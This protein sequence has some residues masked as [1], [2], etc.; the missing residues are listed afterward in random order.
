MTGAIINPSAA[1]IAARCWRFGIKAPASIPQAGWTSSIFMSV[2]LQNDW[3]EPEGDGE[4]RFTTR[5]VSD[6]HNMNFDPSD[7]ILE[8]GYLQKGSPCV[9]C[10]MGG[11]GKSRLLLQLAICSI[12][13]IPF[14]GWQILPNGRP[15]KWLIWQNEND[16]RRLQQDLRA[17]C[18][19]LTKPQI[20]RLSQS[21]FIHTLENDDDPILFLS[22][23]RVVAG[24]EKTNAAVNP[25]VI[26]YDP[27]AS[28][29]IG[30]L[31][32][33]ADMAATLAEIA[34]ITRKG[35]PKRTPLI[36]HHANTGKA[37]IAK[38]VGFDRSS[39]GRNS[40]VLHAWTRAQINFAPYESDNYDTL[41]VSSGKCNN[42]PEFEPFGIT[43]E[44][45]TMTYHR[46]PD[47]DINAWKENMG[48]DSASKHPRATIATVVKIVQEA[49][50]DGIKKAAIARA[51]MEETGV[52]RSYAYDL[53][54]KA[55]AKKAI[56]RRKTDDLY[57][58]PQPPQNRGQK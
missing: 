51:V 23:P 57:V 43:L 21:L 37:G 25:D 42:A 58:V 2:P 32:T 47:V 15:L 12:L 45:D 17:M 40:K 27:L 54:E 53:I 49:G 55:E 11:I 52:G 13:E 6:I 20:A 26:A 30:E 31:N 22:N 3:P 5:N 44:Y 29:R 24:I 1:Q 8:N 48:I 50:L 16:N 18:S 46:D 41:I 39:F 28:F 56:V 14:L 36:L 4:I 34:R 10:G 35:N 38:A 9:W 7:L 33:D 19:I